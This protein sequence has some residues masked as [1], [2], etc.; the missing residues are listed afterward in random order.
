MNLVTPQTA[1]TE[2]IQSFCDS[3][4][5]SPA[6]QEHVWLCLA[7]WCSPVTLGCTHLQACSAII[8]PASQDLSVFSE[9][10]VMRLGREGQKWV[11]YLWYWKEITEWSAWYYIMIILCHGVLMDLVIRM[12]LPCPRTLSVKQWYVVGRVEWWCI[13][14]W[15]QR[16]SHQNE[17][18]I[19]FLCV[20]CESKSMKGKCREKQMVPAIVMQG[21][22]WIYATSSCI[23]QKGC[24]SPS[25][26]NKEGAMYCLCHCT[27]INDNLDVVAS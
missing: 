9:Q 5:I 2:V 19:G 1:T 4:T 11:W 17:L 26:F 7:F 8:S 12:S 14:S 22:N 6:K 15:W 3:G 27:V 16:F 13:E 24:Q 18:T 10:K 25:T 20:A 23:W 21:C